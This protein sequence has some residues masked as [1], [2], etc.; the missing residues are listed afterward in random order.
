MIKLLKHLKPF[1]V[2]IIFIIIFV[3]IKTLADL[4]LPTLMSDIVD[5][6]IVLG[7]T[8]FIIN[9]GLIMLIVAFIGG[10]G[11]IISTNISARVGMSFGRSLR[12]KLFT[13]VTYYSLHEIDQTGTA[14]LITRTTN[15][16][17]QVQTVTIMLLRVA[18]MAPLMAIGSI[19]MAVR[20]DV[21]LTGVIVVVI[22][23]MAIVIALVA[24]K[25]VP[26]F[27]VMQVRVDKLNLVMRER[28]TGLRVIRA[29]NRVKTEEARFEEANSDLTDVAIKV[30]KLMAI[31]MPF[32]ML[33]FSV[34]SVAIIW[35]GAFRVDAGA[36]EVGDMMAFIQYATQVMFAVLMLTM[37]FV[38]VP[39]ASASAIRIHEIL[40]LDSEI[41]NDSKTELPIQSKGEI[42]FKDVS[43]YYHSNHGASEAAIENISFTTKP[44]E[45]TAIIGG[46]GSGKSTLLNLI[47][48]FY[49]IS[50][51][52]ILIDGVSVKK[53]DMKEL[54]KKISLVPQQ[55]VLFSGTVEEN[56]RFGKEDA[57]DE[58]IQ[59]AA[60]IARATE[61]IDEMDEGYK[62]HISQGGS[63]ISGGQKQR[64]S[65]ARAVVRKPEI[66][67]FDDS[68]SALDAKTEAELRGMLNKHTKNAS[69][70]V[71]AQKVTSIMN[72]DQIIVL[73]QGKI[74]GI[75]THKEL[76]QTSE[77]YKEIVASQLSKEEIANG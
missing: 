55:A 60:E 50:K 58:D 16:I 75:G 44:G 20:K 11:S 21:P 41:K 36:I 42:Q 17:V 14:S 66:Y 43:F 67:L 29:F 19:I 27:K 70:I 56:I 15:D 47:P 9:T 51:G 23:L 37:I 8:D 69:L 62:S 25:A 72:A 33:M 6:G 65:I 77:V 64:L 48:R 39:R 52:D 13:K 53:Y 54:R 38:M 7:D 74:A 61:F 28:L 40:E 10:I 63:N 68:F 2:P 12:K 26:M 34:S 76:L 57:T 45:Y 18:T 22:I 71:V 49:D 30:N 1:T 46:T 32:I 73:D 35:F 31:L 24:T 5:E 3:F 4:Y 59:E